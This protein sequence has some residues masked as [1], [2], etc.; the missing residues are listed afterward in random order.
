[1]RKTLAMRFLEGKGVSYEAYTY[2]VDERSAEVVANHLGVSP[3]QVYKTLV[4]VRDY[5]KPLLVMI[6][7]NRHLD[8]K[9]AAKALGEKKVKLATHAEAEDMTRLQVGG[10]SPLALINR[11]FDVVVD[12][13]ATSLDTLYMSAGEKGINLRVAVD[14]LMRLTRARALDVASEEEFAD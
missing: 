11:G 6:P 3:A 12:Q 7:A 5:G 9:K 2:P 8:L 10:I 1:M 4:V 13:S 14:D